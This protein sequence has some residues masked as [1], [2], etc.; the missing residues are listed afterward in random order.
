MKML[1]E[2]LKNKKFSRM[3]LFYGTEE[4]LKKFYLEKLKSLRIK[5]EEELMNLEIFEEKPIS[6]EK[7]EQS[8]LTPPFLGDC[9]FIIVKESGFFKPSKKGDVKEK[10]KDSLTEDLIRVADEIPEDVCVVFLEEEIDKRSKFFKKIQ[11]DGTAVE[12]K[13]PGEAD[14]VKWISREF[15]K[16]KLKIDKDTA[17]YF[18]RY[19]NGDMETAFFEIEKLSAYVAEK[20]VVEKSDIDAVCVKSFQTKIFDLVECMGK[21]NVEKAL[22]IYMNMI[23][24]KE[25]PM[26]IFSMVI[27]QIR[28]M[29]QSKNLAK[30]GY[31]EDEIA[32]KLNL[33]EFMVKE[34]LS[35]AK[36]FTFDE[37]KNAMEDCLETDKKIKLGL[38]KDDLAV[39]LLIIKYGSKKE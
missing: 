25:P 16:R 35:E 30:E 14:I 36:N 5:K 28:M 38:M 32:E 29:Y 19:I 7:I 18:F 23:I 11:K 9:R 13:A 8:V 15:S 17:V 22:E 37:L 26:R 12:F 6:L 39:E 24:T 20:G 1:K 31:R 33:R 3:Y 2:A 34:A 27:R 4:Y 10:G 21:K